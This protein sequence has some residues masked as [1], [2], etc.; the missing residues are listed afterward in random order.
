[1]TRK[2][3]WIFGALHHFRRW[4]VGMQ[5]AWWHAEPDQRMSSRWRAMRSGRRLMR[6]KRNRWES[7][8][9][10]WMFIAVL[11]SS[12]L[13]RIAVPDL[14]LNQLFL[15]HQKLGW[16]AK[17]SHW[18]RQQLS[19]ARSSGGSATRED[20]GERRASICPVLARL[21]KDCAVGAGNAHRQPFLAGRQSE[22]RE[23]QLTL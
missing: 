22:S 12:D 9:R 23:H 7:R 1:L 19:N 5:R 17:P 4:A 3:A 6:L 20:G 14:G 15:L 16:L 13:L 21:G 18:G 11:G 2:F 8:H 10:H